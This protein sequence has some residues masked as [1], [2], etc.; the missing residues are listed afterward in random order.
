MA[1]INNIVSYWKLD[2]NS[3][4]AAGTNNGTDT[5]ITYG[6]A[7][8]RIN[9]GA[10]YNGTTSNINLGNVLGSTFVAA[11][12]VSGWMF[13][14]GGS[15]AGLI[16]KTSGG[17]PHPIDYYIDVGSR[18]FVAY[19]G[20]GTTT[21]M[22][23]RTPNSSIT[24]NAWNFITVTYDGSATIAG[25]RIYING[26]SQTLTPGG[27]NMTPTNG[28]N[29]AIIGSRSDAVTTLTGNMDEVGIWSRVLSAAE[30]STLFNNGAGL[31]HPFTTT[32]ANFLAFM[33]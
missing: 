26:V 24:L 17:I 31:S 1:L 8:G 33:G 28:T 21:Y 25:I 19:L 4:D 2:G 5:A 7:N 13:P 14:T 22:F 27:T 11:H 29:S 15:F 23:T 6:T 12:S 32:N 20:N 16:G 3:T 10:L 18:L 30:V 9:Q